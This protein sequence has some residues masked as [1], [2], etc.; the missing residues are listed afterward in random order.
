MKNP[1]LIPEPMP[2]ELL[3]FFQYIR[4][5]ISDGH[6]L[7]NYFGSSE[8]LIY[9][10]F[11]K[12]GE[13][14]LLSAPF[15]ISE[16]YDSLT[17]EFPAFNM[18]E[19][20][21]YEEFGILPEGHP[22]LKSVRNHLPKEEKHE[23]YPYLMSDSPL[24]HEVGVGPVHAGVIEPGHFRFICKGERVKHL[25]I[26]LGYQH[27]GIEKLFLEGDIREKSHLAE[28][29][30][31]D[32]AIGHNLAYC[33][34]L[35]ALSDSP[36]AAMPIRF[37]ALEMERAAMHLADLSALGTDIAY[38]MG[39]NLFAALRTTVI[40]SALAICGSRFGKRWLTPGGVN[41]GINKE[42]A[43]IL[44]DTLK[45]VRAQVINSAEAMFGNS[46]VLSRFD[47]TGVLSSADVIA[48]GISG[49]AAKA[50]GIPSDARLDFPLPEQNSFEPFTIYSGDVYA[51][52][53]LRYREIIQ[54][55]DI[56]LS[57]LFKLDFEAETK[58]EL[59][60]FSPSSIAISIVEGWRGRIIHMIKTN[61]A[62]EVVWYKML[63]PSFVNWQ[64]LALAM[65]ETAISDFPICNKSFN[66]S[67]CGSDL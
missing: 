6:L 64:G 36:G 32:T 46:S 62:C 56:V 53:L 65:R 4:Q 48:L 12:D 41:Y 59:G 9:A 49:M 34:A 14:K 60:N 66:L 44:R 55:I 61:A 51:R 67:Y 50:S 11:G 19:R 25:E 1:R 21:L 30:A 17:P 2:L 33:L 15:P 27:R 24:L 29:I 37:I 26:Q 13:L 18:Y 43:D 63:D 31:G 54:S 3:D 38:I 58:R 45:E 28:S 20:L 52:A 23:D 57:L 5:L 8:K 7:L 39:Q 35:E 16:S 42:Q 10:L 40:N 22:W 47:D